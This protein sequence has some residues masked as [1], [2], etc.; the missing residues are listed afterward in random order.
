MQNKCVFIY[1]GPGRALEFLLSLEL[2]L[3]FFGGGRAALDKPG[4]CTIFA[5]DDIML[6]IGTYI[7]RQVGVVHK[8]L[9]PLLSH[10]SGMV[11]DS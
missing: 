4:S 9:L 2:I 8:Q 1:L 11:G 10:K 5:H 6:M 3:S 7:Q